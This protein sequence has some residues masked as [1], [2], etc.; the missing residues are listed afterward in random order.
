MGRR[1]RQ[2][3]LAAPSLLHWLLGFSN[4][5]YY[6]WW[7]LTAMSGLMLLHLD[8]N[9]SCSYLCEWILF[10]LFF[11]QHILTSYSHYN[12]SNIILQD[13]SCTFILLCFWV[14][15]IHVSSNKWSTRKANQMCRVQF[16]SFVQILFWIYLL[17]TT[18]NNRFIVATFPWTTPLVLLDWEKKNKKVKCN[19]HVR[20]IP[21]NHIQFL[22]FISNVLPVKPHINDIWYKSSLQCLLTLC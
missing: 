4:Y 8:K 18:Y 22:I 1:W 10:H 11:W 6:I 7:G 5:C 12:S 14:N 20:W 17:D 13:Q 9:K 3:V 19:L 21:K 16:E 15:G 2:K